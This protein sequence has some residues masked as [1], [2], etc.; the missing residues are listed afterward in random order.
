MSVCSIKVRSARQINDP[1]TRRNFAAHNAEFRT[2]CELAGI[3]PTPRQAQKFR[4]GRGRAYEAHQA[5][6]KGGA[7]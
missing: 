7:A 5:A 2:A 1:N 3:K 6:R 4:E